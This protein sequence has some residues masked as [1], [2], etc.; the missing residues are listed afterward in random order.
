MS[1]CLPSF[2]RRL[3]APSVKNILLC[4][5]GGGFDFVHAAAL[6][7]LLRGAGKNVV[8]SSYSFGDPSQIGGDSTVVFE[9]NGAVVKRVTARSEPTAHYGPEVH[10]C[11]F[12]DV[13]YPET[14]PHE[15]Y[16]SNARAFTVPVLTGF[17]GQLV[18]AH[19][20]D[21]VLLVDGGSDS[22]MR[23]DEEGLGDPV[24]D[25]VSI[26]AVAA[27]QRPLTKVVACVGLGTDRFNHVSDGASLRAIAELTARGGFLGA[28]CLEAGGEALGFYEALLE[29]VYARQ[30]FRSVLA[31]AIA[32]SARGAFAQAPIDAR[33]GGRTEPGDVYL[34]PLM[35]MFWAFDVGVVAERSQ[36]VQWIRSCTSV[37]ECYAAL[38]RERGKLSL[39]PIE[40]LPR[41]EDYRNAAG[42]FI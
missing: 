4:G 39:R 14:A 3:T 20:I 30:S 15:V 42:R 11:S 26:A 28:L 12:L 38:L 16:A 41:H 29:H 5:C 40:D 25:A 24:E 34:W 32:T 1:P 13:R 27:L 6:L 9:M 21:A 7:P 19:D 36:L 18:A 2:L 17:Y 8:I 31:G 10:L 22:L 33:F 35:A 23:G 37:D